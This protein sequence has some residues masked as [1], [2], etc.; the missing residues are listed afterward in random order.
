[1][2]NLV[3]LCRHHHRE[4]HKGSFCI[5]LKPA[6]Q[7]AAASKPQRFAERLCFSK[8]DRYF[9]TPFNRTDGAKFTCACCDSTEL[10]KTIPRT[11]Y[12]AIDEKT[13]VTKWAG[14][15]MDIGMALD[16][17][18]NAGRQTIYFKKSL[19]QTKPL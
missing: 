13:A 16:G 3:T 11:I 1:L 14:E 2:D 4:L 6:N 17:L 9:D 5:L 12:N 7:Q 18:L 19:N 15:S 8:G 10:G